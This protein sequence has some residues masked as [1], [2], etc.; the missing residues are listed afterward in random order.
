MSQDIRKKTCLVIKRGNQYLQGW[1]RF[2]KKLDWSPYIYN[3][4]RTRDK[5]LAVKVAS[6]TNGST[7]L[8]NPVLGKTELVVLS[9][10]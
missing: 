3:A 6:R 8:F 4:W 5:E 1:D 9:L 10:G 7:V 2:Y